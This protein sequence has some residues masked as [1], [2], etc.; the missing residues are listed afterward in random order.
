MRRSARI[1]A[2]RD[3]SVLSTQNEEP[4]RIIGKELR[5][6]DVA[7]KEKPKGKALKIPTVGR[8]VRRSSRKNI[9]VEDP[10]KKDDS[11]DSQNAAADPS[12]ESRNKVEENKELHTCRQT[13]DGVIGSSVVSFRESD[14]EGRFEDEDNSCRNDD[15]KIVLLT[16]KKGQKIMKKN[17]AEKENVVTEVEQNT[18]TLAKQL[19]D[20][21]LHSDDAGTKQPDL[22][23]SFVVISTEE[24][25]VENKIKDD[26]V[27]ESSPFSEEINIK[28]EN[29]RLCWSDP[30]T[31]NKHHEDESIASG[32]GLGLIKTGV[33]PQESCHKLST[34]SQLSFK[35]DI[36]KQKTYPKFK[37]IGKLNLNKFHTK[38][39]GKSDLLNLTSEVFQKIPFKITKETTNALKGVNVGLNITKIDD[40]NPEADDDIFQQDVLSLTVDESRSGETKKAVHTL[41]SELDPRIKSSDL[42]F[43]IERKG[44]AP[45]VGDFKLNKKE[46][47]KVLKRSVITS[48]FEQKQ[49]SVMHESDAKKKK[50][51]KHKAKETAGKGWYNLPK[52]EMTD[53]VKRDL[54]VIKMRNV[55]D[56][57]RFYKRG[58][59][60]ISE[61]VLFSILRFL[62][63]LHRTKNK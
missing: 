11:T 1:S 18:N 14:L 25:E 57:K 38:N 33:I 34:H 2:R 37:N 15:E 58:D 59:K 26:I 52:A 3:L 47:R 51:R 55:L 63:L 22:S 30:C 29:E 48:N 7:I 41:S 50:K 12:T 31:D 23:S 10:D 4:H 56:P 9:L 40:K 39:S 46:E 13:P 62:F 20:D 53:E 49:R 28:N 44:T 21:S 43:K 24:V 16:K 35:H 42:Y 17:K 6:V 32:K 8:A 5:T 19:K 54:Q 27:I 36:S 60:K 61:Y 45:I